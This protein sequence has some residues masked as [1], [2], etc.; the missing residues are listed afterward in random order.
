MLDVFHER[1][2]QRRTQQEGH[3]ALSTTHVRIRATYVGNSSKKEI[4]ALSSLDIF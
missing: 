1:D 4:A 3:N 2:T